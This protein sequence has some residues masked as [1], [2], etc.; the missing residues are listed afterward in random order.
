MFYNNE[1]KTY[2]KIDCKFRA[3]LGLF[4]ISVSTFTGCSGDNIISADEVDDK[5][6]IVLSAYLIPSP[7]LESAVKQAVK[8]GVDVRILTNSIR[9]NN[10]LAAHSAYRKHIHNLLKYGAE[11]HEVRFDARDRG[12]YMFAPLGKKTLALHAKVMVIDSDRVFIGSANLDP[13]SFLENSE[14]GVVITSAETAATMAAEFEQV[15]DKG[16]FRLEL[17]TDEEDNEYI[18]WHGYEDGEKVTFDHD[19]HTSIWRRMGV[20]FMRILPI[21]SQL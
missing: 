8:R 18:L 20:G 3:L 13:R 5:E 10:H 15:I 11:L 16:A 17:I 21:E 4:F 12:L 14:I 19:P 6:I 1:V 2:L 7:E 9:S